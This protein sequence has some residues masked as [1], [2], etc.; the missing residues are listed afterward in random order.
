MNIEF[1]K[2]EVRSF[3]INKMKDKTGLSRSHI[4]GIMKG[5][6]E[7]KVETLNK[8]L[9]ELGYT[10]EITKLSFKNQKEVQLLKD[11]KYVLWALGQY[12]MPVRSYEEHVFLADKNTLLLA[13]LSFGR[14]NKEIN[15]VLTLFIFK[16]SN[17]FDWS[18]FV[19]KSIQLK[20][21]GYLLHL[22]FHFSGDPNYNQILMRIRSKVDTQKQES[23]DLEVAPS[24]YYIEKCK[25]TDNIVAKSWGFLTSEDLDILKQKFNRH[26]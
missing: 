4:N 8:L 22:V 6:V 25:L 7:P 9:K 2:E 17:E 19:T 3:G 11:E 5:S 13:A 12:D 14:K 16:F 10:L 1:L 20:Y 15:D 18:R 23:L 21:L 26:V 24:L